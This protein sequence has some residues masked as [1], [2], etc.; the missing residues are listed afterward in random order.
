MGDLPSPDLAALLS[1]DSASDWTGFR[2]ALRDWHAPTQNFVFADDHGDIGAISPGYYPQIA[3]G[4]PR[5]PLDG[6]GADDITGTIPFAAVPQ[7]HNPESHVV[8]TANQRPVGPGYPYYIGFAEDYDPGYRAATISGAMTGAASV[9][10]PQVTAAQTS[11]ADHLAG[12]VVPK[13]L[14]AL[15][16]AHLSGRERDAEALLAGWHDSMDASSPAASVWWTFWQKYLTGTFGPWWTALKV[17]VAR[18]R[19]ALDLTRADPAALMEDLESWTLHDPGNEAFTPPGRPAATAPDVMRRAFTAAVADLAHR[20]GP[21]PAT[22]DWGRLHRRV[23]PSLTAAPPLGYGPLPA[24]G[25]PWTVNAADGGLTSDFG[26][27]WRM[28]V[29][30]T[31][32]G[33]A[34]AEAIYP[35]GQSENPAS[36]WYETFAADWWDGRYRPLP[37]ADRP[38]AGIVWT[39]RPGR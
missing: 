39:L 10:L 17:P 7:V 33:A 22:W 1:I 38:P 28:A 11:F 15:R 30:W 24:G 4:D 27:S 25:D 29:E 34:T 13:L 12:E 9:G 35:G 5:A 14:D 21:T 16:G 37:T 32:P 8:A 20:L 3:A 2:A 26:P 6:T 18:D 23:V 19:A 31:G 36:P